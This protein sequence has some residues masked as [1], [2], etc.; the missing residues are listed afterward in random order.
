MDDFLYKFKY[1]HFGPNPILPEPVKILSPEK[2]R[3]YREKLRGSFYD[4]EFVKKHLQ[5][6]YAENNRCRYKMRFA[7]DL[8]E[9]KWEEAQYIGQSLSPSGVW[10][11][12]CDF[13]YEGIVHLTAVDPDAW[14]STFTFIGNSRV[15]GCASDGH[16]IYDSPIELKLVRRSSLTM[17]FW[18]YSVKIGDD[19]LL[20][21]IERM[22]DGRDP[23]HLDSEKIVWCI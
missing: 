8:K 7:V 2:I 23:I 12:G 11:A 22:V 17:P 4:C 21:S 1:G 20:F 14:F 10:P 5:N 15:I 13:D 6:L 3:A 16:W 9:W 18:M 19:E